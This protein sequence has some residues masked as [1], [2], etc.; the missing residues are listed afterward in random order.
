MRGRGNLQDSEEDIDDS[1]LDDFIEPIED[2]GYDSNNEEE[3]S[4]EFTFYK[5]ETDEELK[6]D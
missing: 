4:D 6:K 3:N 5:V 1:N 2:A